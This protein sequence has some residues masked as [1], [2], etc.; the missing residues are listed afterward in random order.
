M[1]FPNVELHS[2]HKALGWVLAGAL[3]VIGIS[4]LWQVPWMGLSY[5]ALA[6]ILCP[7]VRGPVWAKLLIAL[8]GLIAL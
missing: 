1:S 5:L 6:L 7:V 3:A 2:L 4:L 8:V